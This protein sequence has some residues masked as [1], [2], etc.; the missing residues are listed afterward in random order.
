[1][2]EG[3]H[4]LLIDGFII[5]SFIY[6]IHLSPTLSTVLIQTN[7]LKMLSPV[8][9]TS[10]QHK[11]KIAHANPERLVLQATFDSAALSRSTSSSK[12]TRESVGIYNAAELHDASPPSTKI[13]PAVLSSSSAKIEPGW[14]NDTE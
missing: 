3:L 7:F 13:T 12:A 6:L 9:H 11:T 1:M 10:R 2:G 8:M 5:D 14:W 4:G